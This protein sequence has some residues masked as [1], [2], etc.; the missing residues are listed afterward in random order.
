M[1]KTKTKT[2][3][4]EV[5]VVNDSPG[6]ECRIA[7]LE[8]GHLEELFT[9]RTTTATNVGNIYKGR[10]TNVEPAIQAAFVDYGQGQSG[11]LHISDL[12]PRYFPGSRRTERVG[13]KIP[14]RSRPPIQE[15]LKRNDEVLV[16]V[17]KE[18]IGTK[19]PT[20]TSYLS[21]PGRLL[22]MMPEMDRVGVSRK[23][24][25]PEQ[26]RQMRQVIDTL[27]LPEGFGFIL[28]TAGFGRGKLELHRDVAYL[29]RLWKVME[30]RIKG[31]GA[32][33]EL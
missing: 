8:D 31:V 27:T 13:K 20:L 18:G 7:I 6:E 17:L 26:R 23:V 22:V 1:S 29:T 11:F 25:D 4:R 21:I 16:Q 33:G 15:A 24:E 32:P 19:G 3:P 14:R 12:H 2:T 28:R 30:K 5:M 9:E 10:V